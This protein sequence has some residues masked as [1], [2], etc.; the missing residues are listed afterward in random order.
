MSA[1]LILAKE[2]ILFGRKQMNLFES[3]RGAVTAR[4]A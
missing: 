1:F 2:E 4:E 3:V